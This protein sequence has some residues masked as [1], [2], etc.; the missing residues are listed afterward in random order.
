MFLTNHILG[1]GEAEKILFSGSPNKARSFLLEGQR[2]IG[3]AALAEKYAAELLACS[4]E[5]ITGRSHPDLFM[6]ERQYDEKSEK[7][8]KEIIIEDAREMRNF[9]SRTPSEGTHRVVIVDSADELRMEAA[10]CILKV[11][12]EPPKNSVMI[13][14]SH[15]GY[16]L[17]TIRS[18][19]TFIRLRPLPQDEMCEVISRIMTNVTDSDVRQLC[20]VAEGS[21]GIA[22][23]IYENDGLWMIGELA[24]IFHKFP[25]S[26][27]LQFTKFAE[28][29]AKGGGAKNN[30]GW[31][32][33]CQIFNWYMA[34]IAKA[35][36]KGAEIEVSGTALNSNILLPALLDEITAWQ[37]MQ[38]GAD[39]FN[40]DH[41]Q[42]MVNTLLKIAGCW[43]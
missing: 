19:C 27:Y 34:N 37:E 8:K 28:R 30:K 14:L 39:T 15:G 13:L 31:E 22:Q 26:D 35:A 23:M 20:T 1:H 16:V 17:P 4:L 3:K 42:V 9:L 40:L 18:R 12:E 38:A 6:L 41:K 7:F 43:I 36:A 2:G 10:N 5:R 11:V 33:F 21:P 25:R 29:V 32:V 24:E